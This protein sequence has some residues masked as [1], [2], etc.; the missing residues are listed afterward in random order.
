[1]P[2]VTACYPFSVA[3]QTDA[4]IELVGYNLSSDNRI[5]IKTAGPGEMEVPLDAEHFRKRHP[6]KL[7]VTEQPELREIEPNDDP[8]H[9]MPIRAPG[10]VAGRIMV[11]DSDLFRFMA[12]SNQQF[13]IETMAARKGSPV[14]TKIEILHAEGKP[15]QR[16]VLQAVRNSAITFRGIDSNTAD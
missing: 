8:A 15:V 1:F 10:S 5:K 13:V 6:F 11:G 12:K 9:A 7:L 2:Y 14:D 3:A 16:L 4:E